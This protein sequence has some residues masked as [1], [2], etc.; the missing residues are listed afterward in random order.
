MA[1]REEVDAFWRSKKAH[2]VGAW[3]VRLAD[4]DTI[5]ILANHSLSHPLSPAVD[6]NRPVRLDF[7]LP[8]RGRLLYELT[9]YIRKHRPGGRQNPQHPQTYPK[10]LCCDPLCPRA[11]RRQVHGVYQPAPQRVVD[12]HRWRCPN[13]IH[14]LQRLEQLGHAAR[15]RCDGAKGRLVLRR[16]LLGIKDSPMQENFGIVVGQPKQNLRFVWRFVACDEESLVD[17]L[18]ERTPER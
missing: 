13:F 17:T 7:Q 10:A 4:A 15:S 12:H 6:R 1:V 14:R 2:E 9:G 16:S 18:T 3:C 8:A 11:F 5:H